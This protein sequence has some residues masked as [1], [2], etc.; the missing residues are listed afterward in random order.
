MAYSKKLKERMVEVFRETGSYRVTAKHFA[1]AYS[2]VYYAVNP[3]AY[4]RHKE[5]VYTMKYG[6]KFK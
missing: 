3:D 2:T 6:D 4:E 1:C 5:H